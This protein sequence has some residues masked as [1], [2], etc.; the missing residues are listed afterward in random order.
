MT[1]KVHWK[2]RALHHKEVTEV[3]KSQG[4]L[5][6]NGRIRHWRANNFHKIK[7]KGHTSLNIESCACRFQSIH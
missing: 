2:N 3:L 1:T 6:Q 5:D 4:C 7:E